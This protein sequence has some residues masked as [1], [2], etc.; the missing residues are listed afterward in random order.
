MLAR[1]HRVEIWSGR[2]DEVAG[3]TKAWLMANGLGALPVSALKTRKIGDHRPDTVLKAEWLDAEPTP[4]D[5]VFEDRAS[6]V[7][8]Y[9]ERGIRCCQVAP[10]DF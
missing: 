8:M 4:P 5:L 2:S 3:K 9:R 1:R 10:G 6:M 7:A